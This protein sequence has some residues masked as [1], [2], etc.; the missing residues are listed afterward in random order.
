M[1]C[2][3]DDSTFVIELNATETIACARRIVGGQETERTSV[4]G[5][6][7]KQPPWY[8]P[9]WS[10]HLDPPTID[11]FAM[12]TEVCDATPACVEEHLDEVGGAFLPDSVWCPWCSRVVREIHRGGS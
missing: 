8:N 12:A 1:T 5:T 2:S 3:A 6:V 7:I 9:Q 4:M 11:F 10:Y